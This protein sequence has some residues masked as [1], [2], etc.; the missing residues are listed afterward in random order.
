MRKLNVRETSWLLVLVL[1]LVAL[2]LAWPRASRTLEYVNRDA[3]VEWGSLGDSPVLRM[4]LLAPETAALPSR[5]RNLF[6]YYEPDRQPPPAAPPTPIAE[7]D[8]KPLIPGT[9]ETPSAPWKRPGPPFKYIGFLGP[10]NERIAVF[11]RGNNVFVAR[12]GDPVGDGFELLKFRHDAVVLRYTA[13]AYE[14]ETTTL[15]M[16]SS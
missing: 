2:W 7:V 5:G 14:G 1:A 12:V 6:A 10:K 9:A 8:P 13:G 11:D 3:P 15:S 16:R 4:D